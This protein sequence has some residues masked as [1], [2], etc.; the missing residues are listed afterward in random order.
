MTIRELIEELNKFDGDSTVVAGIQ[1]WECALSTDLEVAE[2]E[3]RPWLFRSQNGHDGGVVRLPPDT[4]SV[5]A[6]CARDATDL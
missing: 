4:K 5:V 6:I 2:F 1:F 3:D